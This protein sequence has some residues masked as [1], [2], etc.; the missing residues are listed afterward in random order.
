MRFFLKILKHEGYSY[1]RDPFDREIACNN[2]LEPWSGNKVIADLL[3]KNPE[4]FYNETKFKIT[5]NKPFEFLIFLFSGGVSS[6]F[7]TVNLSEFC[8]KIF[9]KFDGFLSF[10]SNLFPLSKKIVLQK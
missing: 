4:R 5:Y 7:N 3:F 1:D 10:F 8:L 6:E 9:S 2:P